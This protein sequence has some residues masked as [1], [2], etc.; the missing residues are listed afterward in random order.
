MRNY[1]W[2]YFLISSLRKFFS[3]KFNLIETN[4]LISLFQ[5][6]SA[7]ETILLVNSSSD[8][9]CSQYTGRSI[10]HLEAQLSVSIWLSVF[11]VRPQF[12]QYQIDLGVLVKADHLTW[13]LLTS[14]CFGVNNPYFPLFT[15]RIR[16]TRSFPILKFQDFI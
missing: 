9:G 5:S 11:Q 13:Y 4:I 12:Y 6:V 8:T 15:L 16:N 10:L 1:S 14:K 2:K 3:L 7:D